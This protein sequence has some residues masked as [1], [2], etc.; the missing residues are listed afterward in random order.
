VHCNRWSN[1]DCKTWPMS[2]W[3][4]RPVAFARTRSEAHCKMVQLYAC[5][6]RITRMRRSETI[7]GLILRPTSDISTVACT[8][9]T[10]CL[11]KRCNGTAYKHA[12]PEKGGTDT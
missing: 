4:C 9:A 8:D 5:A 2:R 3:L 1:A 11:V 12:R 7:A 6:C 10:G